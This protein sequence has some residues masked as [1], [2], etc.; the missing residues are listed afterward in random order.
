VANNIAKP[1]FSRERKLY[2]N[3]RRRVFAVENCP[4]VDSARDRHGHVSPRPGSSLSSRIRRY[5][6]LIRHNRS[7]DRNLATATAGHA[8]RTPGV[9]VPPRY[10]RGSKY[11]GWR[12]YRQR[13]GTV[14][15][16]G[17]PAGG[18]IRTRFSRTILLSRF[19]FDTTF[20]FVGTASLTTP[21][22][23]A[24]PNGR[25]NSLWKNCIPRTYA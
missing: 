3:D 13:L 16:R 20:D 23:V 17:Y 9:S 12:E 21:K 5:R 4:P 8:T 18:G 6:T 25:S 10:V 15:Y 11:S 19:I 7:L 1:D 2:G 14:G 22:I 24:R